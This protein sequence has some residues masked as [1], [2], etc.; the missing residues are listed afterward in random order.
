MADA[1]FE[2]G[3]GPIGERS[4]GVPGRVSKLGDPLFGSTVTGLN[5]GRSGFNGFNEL[6]F[7][8]FLDDGRQGIAVAVP[9]NNPCP[10]DVDGSGTVDTGDL[11]ALFAQW[12]TDGPA[13]F[14]GSGA[15]GTGDLLILFAN[16]GP[17][18]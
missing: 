16:W 12:G 8:Y 11:L 18:P 13:D 14:D 9:G 10:W 5:L 17:C 4:E 2:A 15:V 7:T 1:L 6:G 3:M